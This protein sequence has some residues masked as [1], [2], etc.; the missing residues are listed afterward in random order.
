MFAKLGL[1][2][3]ALAMALPA[4]AQSTATISS[5]TET[6]CAA[7]ATSTCPPVKALKLGTNIQP[8]T[9]SE[10]ESGETEED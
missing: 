9:G 6:P 10:D 8:A 1:A 3:L 5:G 4:L 7:S 2:A